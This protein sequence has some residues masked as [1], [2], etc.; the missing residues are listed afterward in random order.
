[1]CVRIMKIPKEAN[2][3]LPGF[4]AHASHKCIANSLHVISILQRIFQVMYSDL[5]Q[6]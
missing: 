4:L 1:M 6:T 3:V 2:V 5:H